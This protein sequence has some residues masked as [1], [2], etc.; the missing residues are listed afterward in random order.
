MSF[1]YYFMPVHISLCQLISLCISLCLM[2]SASRLRQLKWVYFSL[3]Q[4]MSLRMD[5]R[6]Q[7]FVA[8]NTSFIAMLLCNLGDLNLDLCA[9]AVFPFWL[10]TSKRSDKIV[11]DPA[12]P[13]CLGENIFYARRAAP[14]QPIHS[15]A[16]A[17]KQ[18]RDHRSSRVA[19]QHSSSS[20]KQA[21]T[22][23]QNRSEKF[24]RTLP[25][26]GFEGSWEAPGRLPGSS[27]APSKQ[28]I[29]REPVPEPIPLISAP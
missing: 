27:Q 15:A 9:N 2:M 12:D 21:P 4:F 24:A 6:S 16:G 14:H 28:G 26:W 5:T 7:Y 19:R 1:L 11:D 25:N 3:L 10:A 17:A 20:R 18:R 13:I 8:C 23:L 29:K 22:T